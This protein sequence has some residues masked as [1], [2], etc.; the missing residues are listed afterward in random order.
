MMRYSF[1]SESLNNVDE[2]RVTIV[3]KS[4]KIVA[5]KGSKQVSGM[6]SGEPGNFVTICTGVNPASTAIPPMTIFP[7]MNYK[8]HFFRYCPLGCTGASDPSGWMIEE[9]FLKF[10]QHFMKR[11]RCSK[12]RKILLLL[13]NHE[14]LI[15]IEALNYVKKNGIT[16]EDDDDSV[17]F[18]LLIC[19]D[20]K[21]QIMLL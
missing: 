11:T 19:D 2:T 8:E 12:D 3:H 9:N 17:G 18:D 15:S 20:K 4:I 13:D 21:P 16:T 1:G 7:R 10:V 14:S 5:S 6:T